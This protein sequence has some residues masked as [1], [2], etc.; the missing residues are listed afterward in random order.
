MLSTIQDASGSE[1]L[2]RKPLSGRPQT[3]RMPFL[4][5]ARGKH[6]VALNEPD[7]EVSKSHVVRE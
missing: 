7:R 3:F 6:R 5:E 2:A 1:V 4:T